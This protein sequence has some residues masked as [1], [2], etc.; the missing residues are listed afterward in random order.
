MKTTKDSD[1][2]A[3]IR[4]EIEDKRTSTAGLKTEISA[5][6]QEIADLNAQ[7]N[8]YTDVSNV[9]AYS[10]LK[11]N[12]EVRQNKLEVLRRKFKEET[13]LQDPGKTDV[14]INGFITEKRKIDDKYA[15]EMIEIIKGLETIL[16]EA[17][18]KRAEI[19]NIY[20]AWTMEFR[21]DRNRVPSFVEFDETTVSTNVQ[22]LVNSLR[23][24]G[25]LK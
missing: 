17:N 4:K 12:M 5:L 11:D 22:K 21:P 1:F 14:V 23:I 20:D 15:A 18:A 7:I 10:D 16:K 19:K 6:E 9:K 24:M 8:S 25:K 2:I 3:T 13:A